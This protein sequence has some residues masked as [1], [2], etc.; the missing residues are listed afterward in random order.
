MPETSKDDLLARALDRLVKPL[1]WTESSGPSGER[2][3]ADTALGTYEVIGFMT[4]GRD[5]H[6][7]YRWRGPRMEARQA[8]SLED[9]KA[10]AAAHHRAAIAGDLD[11]DTLI[12]AGTFLERDIEF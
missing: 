3:Y 10:K 1:A 9:A 8:D 4:I 11:R 5:P 2:S 12:R 6:M 7:A